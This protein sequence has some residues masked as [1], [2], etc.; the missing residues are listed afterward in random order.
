MLSLL[1]S[2]KS[3]PQVLTQSFVLLLVSVAA[4]TDAALYLHSKELLAVY[5]TGDT[6]KLGQF[7]SQDNF[8][9]ALPLAGIVMTFLIGTIAAAW[10]G[11]RMGRWR[12]P[13]LL[14]AVGLLVMAGWPA[15]GPHYPY[16]LVILLALAM[17]TLNQVCK[18]EPGV[19]FVTGTLVKLGR[20][21]AAGDFSGALPL[22]LRWFVWLIAAFI[23]AVLD[24]HFPNTILL[25]IAVWLLSLAGLHLLAQGAAHRHETHSRH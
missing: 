5:I 4:L 9:K 12:A 8:K 11:K 25:I 3:N 18:Q 13:M 2:S 22:L 19:T 23:G 1:S 6:S 15:S 21:I 24:R 20:A 14:L 7:V 17:G 10:G 16:H